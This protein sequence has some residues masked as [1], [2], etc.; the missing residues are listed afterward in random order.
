MH[1]RLNTHTARPAAAVLVLVSLL[2]GCQLTDTLEQADGTAATSPPVAAA[3]SPAPPP[4]SESTASESPASEPPAE[5]ACAPEDLSGISDTIGGQLMAF[6][7]GD[8]EAAL[9]FATPGF[10]DS[11][12]PQEFEAMITST[13][14]VP[15]TATAHQVLD[16]VRLADG[17]ATTVRVTG[18]GGQQDYSY[19]LRLLADGW[20]IDGAVP[21][22]GVDA[23]AQV[24]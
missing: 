1:L 21:V 11:F 12:T 8:F 2:S 5:T 23:P 15:A 7:D 9:G 22:G 14:P 3:E 17:A 19:G 6:A 4:A 24:I 16:C 18:A 20:R 13:F 10:R